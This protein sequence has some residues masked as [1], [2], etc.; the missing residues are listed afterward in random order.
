MRYENNKKVDY[1]SL[2]AERLEVWDR[3]C[4]EKQLGWKHAGRLNDV[5]SSSS[6]LVVVGPQGERV[7]AEKYSVRVPNIIIFFHFLF[8]S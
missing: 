2:M 6:L 4:E 7:R 3:M 1:H 8:Y 5:R